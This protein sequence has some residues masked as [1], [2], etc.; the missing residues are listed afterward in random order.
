MTILTVQS[1]RR[2]RRFQDRRRAVAAA[3]VTAMA[4]GASLHLSFN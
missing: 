1:I 4:D 2:A 3:V